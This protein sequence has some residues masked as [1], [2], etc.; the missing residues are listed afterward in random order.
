MSRKYVSVKSVMR[1]QVCDLIRLTGDN[2]I[3]YT[4]L[5]YQVMLDCG[6]S[7][8]SI[9]EWLDDLKDDGRVEFNDGG[10]LVWLG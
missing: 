7:R 6:C 8:E 10:V 5:K 1:K 2:G 9:D 4:T 3:P